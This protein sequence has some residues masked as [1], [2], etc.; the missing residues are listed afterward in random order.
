MEASVVIH[1]PENN[2]SCH[3]S[4]SLALV[5]VCRCGVAVRTSV[6]SM[7]VGFRNGMQAGTGSYHEAPDLTINSP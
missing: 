6:V 7:C 5:Q 1:G 2:L 4:R 3:V